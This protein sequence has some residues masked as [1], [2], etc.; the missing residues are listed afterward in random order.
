[1][2][3]PVKA[4]ILTKTNNKNRH[5]PRRFFNYTQKPLTSKLSRAVFYKK[6]QGVSVLCH[7]SKHFL[8]NLVLGWLACKKVFK[9]VDN[10]L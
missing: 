4:T 2:S 6:W 1:M 7:F 8:S 10:K 3:K 9:L 5:K